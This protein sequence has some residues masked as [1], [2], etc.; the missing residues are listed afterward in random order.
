MARGNIWGGCAFRLEGLTG[1]AIV[2]P[3]S[4]KVR[5]ILNKE[6]AFDAVESLPPCQGRGSSLVLPR[7]QIRPS[8]RWACLLRGIIRFHGKVLSRGSLKMLY[9]LLAHL[10]DTRERANPLGGYVE[11]QIVPVRRCQGTPGGEGPR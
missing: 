11:N 8:N 9:G 3:R 10:R 1:S 7:L 4:S 2:P 6:R 5:Y